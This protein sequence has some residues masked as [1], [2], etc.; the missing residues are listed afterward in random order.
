MSSFPKIEFPLF[1]KVVLAYTFLAWIAIFGNSVFVWIV[2]SSKNR[3][4]KIIPNYLLCAQCLPDI[5]VGFLIGVLGVQVYINNGLPGTAVSSYYQGMKVW[6]GSFCTLYGVFLHFFVFAS[7]YTHVLTTWERYSSIVYPMRKKIGFK[8]LV[9]YYLLI[10]G[11]SVV[12]ACAPFTIGGFYLR[13]GRTNCSALLVSS[14]ITIA[15]VVGIL[16][17]A[18]FLMSGYGIMFL[19]IKGSFRSAGQGQTDSR[20]SKTE[21]RIAF[22]FAIIVNCFL[23]CCLPAAFTWFLAV[24]GLLGAPTS[25]VFANIEV[26]GFLFST[27]NSAINPFLYVAL[28]KTLRNEM[29]GNLGV[30]VSNL[31]TTNSAVDSAQMRVSVV[32]MPAEQIK[33]KLSTITTMSSNIQNERRSRQIVLVSVSV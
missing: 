5:G 18:N 6:Q 30:D 28:N 23:V 9:R 14:P 22:Q 11:A 24:A 27:L 12:F 32:T 2:F 20:T 4:V 13:P 1:R 15:V 3:R 25:N 7:G 31:N 19:K 10:W 8:T 33:P 26:L 29:L 16:V 17:A 21:K